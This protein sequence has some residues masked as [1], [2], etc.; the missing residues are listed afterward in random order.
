MSPQTRPAHPRRLALV[1][2]PSKFSDLTHVKDVVARACEQHGWPPAQWYT[3]TPTDPGTSQAREAIKDGATLVCP[4]GGD[5]T[6]R[7]VASALVGSPIP[8]GLLPG[9]TGNLLARNLKLPTDD[10]G[11]ALSVALT[12]RDAP[13]D[14]GIVTWDAGEPTVFLVMAGMG[15]D[16]ETM[17]SA[18]DRL[19]RRIGWL[20]Y[21]ISGLKA[22]V[23]PGFG[24]RVTAG[25]QREVSQHA[26]MVVVGNCGELTGGVSLMPDAR[27][28]DG[29]L[30]VVLVTPRSI[31]GWLPVGLHLLTGRRRGH[32]AVS[33]MVCREVEIRTRRPV[34]AQLDGDAVG[35]K[36]VMV[37]AVRPGLL[38]VRLPADAT[39]RTT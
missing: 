28:E 20:A 36:R 16:A 3:T 7:A 2:N 8:V 11:T 34:Q 22:L 19:K 13:I 38:I 39:L 6:V 31:S 4:L 18:S 1:V 17:A 33:R 5:G 27:V 9:G 24:V 37:C 29:L 15:L 26:R 14:V 12:G 21:V 30:D 32:P 10:L 25:S 23:N 35:P